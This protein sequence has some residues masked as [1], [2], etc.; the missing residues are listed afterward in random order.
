MISTETM[1]IMSDWI[2]KNI[3]IVIT[4]VDW[5]RYTLIPDSPPLLFCLFY[6]AT[7]MAAALERVLEPPWSEHCR[8]IPILCPIFFISWYDN[9]PRMPLQVHRYISLDWDWI[10]SRTLSPL[11]Q[12][13]HLLSRTHLS[14]PWQWSPAITPPTPPFNPMSYPSN[15]IWGTEYDYDGHYP[16]HWGHSNQ[17]GIFGTPFDHN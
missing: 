5:V 17:L 7:T 8:N 3:I 15:I 2:K 1:K 14:Q 13:P 11:F 16:L 6:S 12:R 9:V 4:N 10:P